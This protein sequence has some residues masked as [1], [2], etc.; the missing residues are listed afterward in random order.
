VWSICVREHN[1][2]EDVAELASARGL[3]WLRLHL[4]NVWLAMAGRS[5]C[6]DYFAGL[7]LVHD[8]F[9]WLLVCFLFSFNS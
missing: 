6:P 5:S 3:Y 8:Y 1:G 2:G 4:I 7:F 9:V